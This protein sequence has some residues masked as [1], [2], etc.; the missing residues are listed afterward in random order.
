LEP[1]HRLG[2]PQ[3]IFPENALSE[4]TLDRWKQSVMTAYDLYATACTP[5]KVRVRQLP[6]WACVGARSKP[7]KKRRKPIR[8]SRFSSEHGRRDVVGAASRGATRHG[9][10]LRSGAG[11]EGAQAPHRPRAKNEAIDTWRGQIINRFL[12]GNRTVFACAHERSPDAGCAAAPRS[13]GEP[14]G[15]GGPPRQTASDQ[16]GCRAARSARADMRRQV[17]I[18]SPSWRTLQY[19]N[20]TLELVITTAEPQTRAQRNEASTT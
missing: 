5:V 13:A 15:N 14:E 18:R 2:A 8:N 20:H 16:G 6:C 3:C 19:S 11:R 17:E 1:P 7:A 10:P 9:P 4:P 12:A